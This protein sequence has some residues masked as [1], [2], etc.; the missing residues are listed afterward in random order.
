MV[1]SPVHPKPSLPPLIPAPLPPNNPDMTYIRQCSM[2]SLEGRPGTLGIVEAA[3]Q[4]SFTTMTHISSDKRCLQPYRNKMKLALTIAALIVVMVTVPAV[5]TRFI[6][7]KT[8]IYNSVIDQKTEIH[9]IVI[10]QKTEV[11][12]TNSGVLNKVT[13]VPT[14]NSRLTFNGM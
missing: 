8:E 6:N 4:P 2:T 10:N 9:N 11:H 1:S 12:N 5:Y 3:N 14:V 13:E 7:Q